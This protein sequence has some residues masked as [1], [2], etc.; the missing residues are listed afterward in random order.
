MAYKSELQNLRIPTGHIMLEKQ[1]RL[2]LGIA[3]DGSVFF[4]VASGK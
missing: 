3:V 1:V 2:R 4:D